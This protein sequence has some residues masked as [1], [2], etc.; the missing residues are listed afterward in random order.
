MLS[1]HIAPFLCLAVLAGV[2]Y[3]A[4]V[5]PV[6]SKRGYWWSHHAPVHP[7]IKL[8][9]SRPLHNVAVVRADVDGFV[10][11]CFEGTFK[12]WN[13]Q[14]TADSY[15]KLKSIAPAPVPTPKF[16]SLFDEPASTPTPAEN[17]GLRF[18]FLDL[19]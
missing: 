19:L 18:K 13:T 5:K 2:G 16:S 12:L 14:L 1:R 10:V 4:T 7:V 3:V 8:A 15:S 6:L 11:S 17:G 9:N